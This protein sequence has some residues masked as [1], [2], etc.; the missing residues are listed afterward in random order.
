MILTGP[1]PISAPSEKERFVEWLATGA[2]YP[3]E[4][5]DLIVGV[6]RLDEARSAGDTPH[7]M[8]D[9]GHGPPQRRWGPAPS[10]E[11]AHSASVAT[12]AL[13]SVP[14]VAAGGAP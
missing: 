2:G 7:A 12:V 8:L 1:A 6:V 14:R 9:G 3:G 11:P 10:L 4:D 5:I 13:A